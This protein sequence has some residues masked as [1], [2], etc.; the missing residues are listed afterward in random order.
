MNLKWRYKMFL[1]EL[2]MNFK[3]VTLGEISIDNKGDYGIGASAVEYSENL[4]TYLR[5]TDINDD[6]TLNKTGMKSVDDEN[7]NK[8]ILQP[9]DIVFART[10]NSTG[11]SYFYE[12]SDGELVY[13]G[14]LIKFSLDPLKVNP[15]Y[16]KYYTLSSDYKG[17]INS[18]NTGSTRGNIN[19]KTYA[20]MSLNLPSRAQQNL[21][22]DTLEPLTNKIDLNNQT[23]S[24]LE[25]I[26]STLFK[27]WF[28]DFEFPDEDRN[29][30]KSSGGKMVVSE[31]GEIPEGWRISSLPEIANYQ[32]GLA[33]QKFR[34]KGEASLPVIKIK[35][36]S[37]GFVDTNSERCDIDIKDSVTIYNGDVIF[38]WSATLLVKIWT[39]GNG[40]LNQHL[41]KV[42]SDEY[43][44]WFYYYWTKKHIDNFINIAKDKATTMGH[45][46]KKHLE[47]ACV[48]IPNANQ[49]DLFDEIMTPFVDQLLNIGLENETLKELR[50][51]LL[52]KLLSGEIELPTETE[53]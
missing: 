7:A 2:D 48:L 32:N 37:Q 3:S 21:L 8:Y 30:Y 27:H 41:F 1:E 9:N 18:F 42:T 50:D 12:S 20:N 16:M 44:K 22:V 47:Q 36:L 28:V 53:V 19:A 29:P 49:M 13:A 4:P 23:I 33:M 46:N 26:A 35:E 11:K 31:I 39:G 15:R 14:F 24:S 51:T 25:E 6:G 38:S 10:G 45:I 34:P 40:G 5:I 17:W 43:P 52:P